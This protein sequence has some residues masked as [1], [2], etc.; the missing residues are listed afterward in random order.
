MSQSGEGLPI[1][2]HLASEFYLWLWWA[3]E[4]RESMFDLGADVGQVVVWVDDRLAFRNA[5]DLRATAVLTGEAPAAS[6]EAKA[7]L[8][9]GKVL[10][11]VRIGIRRD[12]REHILTLSGP[13]MD[14]KQLKLPAFG[15]GEDGVVFDRMF[16]YE[17]VCY[18]LS[19]LF[20]EFSAVRVSNAWDDTV[21]P[22]LVGWC[23]GDG[24]ETTDTL[25]PTS[26]ARYEAA[27]QA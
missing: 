5:N 7:A 9:G 1:V 21:L 3:S 26:P 2:P 14:V 18:V 10:H 22:E 11:E 17:E 25:A 6:L 23:R 12:D 8:R 4:Q 13:A 24:V 20:S 16:L 15:E 19:A 27:P